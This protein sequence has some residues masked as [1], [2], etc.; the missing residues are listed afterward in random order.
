MPA[1]LIDGKLFARQYKEKLAAEI[2]QLKAQTHEAPHLC[3]I[4][5]GNPPSAASY[6]LSQRRTAEEIGMSY[7]I[8]DLPAGFTEADLVREIKRLNADKKISGIMVYK[9]LPDG[10]NYQKVAS[11]I[12]PDKDI[13]G[14]NLANIGRLFLGETTLAPC[15]AEAAFAL[16]Q[17]TKVP[18]RGKEA[19]VV[20]VSEIVGKP[21]FALLLK[22]RATV[23]ICHR[24]TSEAGRLAEH[25]G[26]ADIV[27]AAIGKPQFVKGEWIK[28]GAIVIDVGINQVDNKIV[29]EVEF[30]PALAR[31]GFITPVPGGV[32]PVTVVMLMRNGIEAFKKQRGITS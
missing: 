25:V 31:A 21:L 24:G 3:N 8:K 15:T 11:Q 26:R 10:I 2:K 16:I 6:A 32:G 23:T 17:S 22:E 30:D 7:E 9:P 20:G 14:V 1:Q 12:D 13:E 18:L 19:V 28:K 27:V 5:V 29:G 4:M